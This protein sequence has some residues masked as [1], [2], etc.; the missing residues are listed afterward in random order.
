MYTRVL[1]AKRLW[2][3]SRQLEML[4]MNWNQANLSRVYTVFYNS[5]RTA[6]RIHV[7]ALFVH[8][9]PWYGCVG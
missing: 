4:M 2:V 1:I 5:D 9:S 6:L 3:L 7:V 8:H